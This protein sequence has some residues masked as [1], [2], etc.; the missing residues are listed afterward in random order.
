MIYS[1]LWLAL[2]ASLW[3]AFL[4]DI[5]CLT[6]I[7]MLKILRVLVWG[8]PNIKDKPIWLRRPRLLLLLLL[9]WC[10]LAFK[11]QV[12]TLFTLFLLVLYLLTRCLVLRGLVMRL[13][14]SYRLRVV[15]LL[16]F[17]CNYCNCYE[18]GD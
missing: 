14:L 4:C 1:L 5:F 7:Y 15:H 12:T 11:M 6:C 2:K 9:S 17:F 16:F 8:S 10:I 13:C 18:I 3:L